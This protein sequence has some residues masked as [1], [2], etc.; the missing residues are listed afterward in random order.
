MPSLS[1]R[2][3]ATS[4]NERRRAEPTQRATGT[5]S[6]TGS[7]QSRNGAGTRARS[8]RLPSPPT[9]GQSEKVPGSSGLTQPESSGRIFPS[10]WEWGEAEPLLSAWDHSLRWNGKGT[11]ASKVFF[12]TTIPPPPFVFLFWRGKGCTCCKPGFGLGRLLASGAQAGDCSGLNVPVGFLENITAAFP[13]TNISI[14]SI[15]DWHFLPQK[16][17]QTPE[18]PPKVVWGQETPHPARGSA[19]LGAELSQSPTT[20]GDA[21]LPSLQTGEVTCPSTPNS[22]FTASKNPP[23]NPPIAFPSARDDC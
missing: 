17:A 6:P 20:G 3:V 9:P 2:V 18:P 12:S 16:L 7:S 1:G 21:A 15:P 5:D 11:G 19:G 8:N 4:I 14:F 22:S 13:E 10:S 23:Q